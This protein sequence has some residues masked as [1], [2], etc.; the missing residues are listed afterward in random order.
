MSKEGIS[1][2][3]ERVK[4]IKDLPSPVNKKG[5]ESFLRK[6]NFVS[7]FIPDF[8]RLLN[9]VTLIFWKNKTFK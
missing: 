7:R 9:L 8:A 3:M 4:S 2:D 6:I 1:I 5:V